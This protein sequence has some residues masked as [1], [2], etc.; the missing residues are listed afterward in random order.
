MSVRTDEH[1]QYL[2]HSPT[3]QPCWG[4]D[5]CFYQTNI[6]QNWSL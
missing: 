3:Y 4:G 6:K 1:I 2:D 5:I